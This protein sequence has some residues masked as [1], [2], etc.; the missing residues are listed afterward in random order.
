MMEC[1]FSILQKFDKS[2]VFDF[3]SKVYDEE[4][5]NKKSEKNKKSKRKGENV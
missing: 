5:L 2:Y 3:T 1:I 4:G